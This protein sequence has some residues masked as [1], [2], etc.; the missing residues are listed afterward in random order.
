M[1]KLNYLT[2]NEFAQKMTRNFYRSTNLAIRILSVVVWVLGVIFLFFDMI[3]G[4]LITSVFFGFFLSVSFLLKVQNQSAVAAIGKDLFQEE[5]EMDQDSF[6]IKSIYI[7]REVSNRVNL[8][9][10]EQIYWSNEG[11]VMKVGMNIFFVQTGTFE[12]GSMSEI[13]DIL[14]TY[15]NIKMTIC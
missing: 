5:L 9:S 6:T 11:F 14:K 7:S 3:Y 10:V 13:F 8:S 15:E 2:T 12:S 4:V 1:I